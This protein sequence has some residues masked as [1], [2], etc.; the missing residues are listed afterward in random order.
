MKKIIS[1]VL[2][3]ST[4]LMSQVSCVGSYGLFNKIL[5]WNNNVSNKF[6]NELIY[7]LFMI[8]PVYSIAMFIDAI[9][10]N[11]IE[12][13]TGS[14]PLAM[15][16]G[17]VEQQL[18]TGKDGK[19]YLITAT[20]NKFEIK[21]LETEEIGEL[22]YNPTAMSWTATENGN[23]TTIIEGLTDESGKLTGEISVN[24]PNQTAMV[25]DLNTTDMAAVKA[26]FENLGLTLAS[27]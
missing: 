25:Y 12:F 6:V 7:L 20:K 23:S 8:L 17:D 16:E 19:D 4:L 15:N 22:I 26:D 13:W 24:V 5:D 18:V 10:I 2:I 1:G 21:D 11:T 9:I 14:N 3:G 27:K